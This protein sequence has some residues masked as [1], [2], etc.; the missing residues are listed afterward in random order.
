MSG[1]LF[2]GSLFSAIAFMTMTTASVALAATTPAP[3]V[4][5]SQSNPQ[6]EQ[7]DVSDQGGQISNTEAQSQPVQSSSQ[8]IGAP[9]ATNE[10]SPTMTLP[11]QSSL[12]VSQRLAR[13]QQQIDNLAAMNLP[14]QIS[15]L[16]QSLAQL[17]G[18]LQ[19]QAHDLK[20]LNDQQRSFYQD[21]DQRIDQLKNLS[22][23]NSAS[24]NSGN[25]KVS[26][27]STG[28]AS[29][30]IN[31]KDA[32]AYQ[33]AFNLLAK[34][35][36][37]KSEASFQN[38]LSDY[39]NGKYVSNAHYWLGEIYLTQKNNNQAAQQFQTV[40][41]KFPKSP[42]IADAKLKLAIIHADEGKIAQARQELIQLKKQHPSS[43]AAQLASIRLQQL[44]AEASAKPNKSS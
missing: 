18:Q 32:N 1:K 14:Q 38:Y 25:T 8:I 9:S 30:N 6:G 16:Q 15:D 41:T 2:L 42:K 29:N 39:P 13:L 23:G 26:N 3:V 7:V 33:A 5:V 10:P 27:N 31:T 40:M 28:A 20:L 4:D 37:D 19:V 22:S 21:L 24:D 17:R 43:T 44:D 12:T 34:K 35:Q 36:Y 11:E